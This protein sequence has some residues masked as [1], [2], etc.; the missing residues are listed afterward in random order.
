MSFWTHVIATSLAL[1]FLIFPR[2]LRWAFGV[3]L[4][5]LW[6]DILKI[7]RFTILKN[8]TIAFPDESFE[9]RKRLARL[10]M[11]HLCYNFV[12]FCLLP[13][14]NQ[15]WLQQR[16]V[17][18]GIENYERA[19]SK[20]KGVLIL[21][22]HLG[23]GDVGL[24]A[25]ALAGL[26]LHVISKKFR[27]AFA[28]Q[29]WFGVREKMGTRFLEPHGPSLA[30]DILKACKQNEAVVFVLDQFMGRP[31]GIETTFFGQKTGTAYGLALFAMKTKAPVLPVYTYRDAEL[32][33]HVVF[34]EEVIVE[35]IEDKD[36]QIRLMTQKYNDRVESIVRKYPEQWMWVHRRW[37]RWE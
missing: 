33:T 18:H 20:G 2:Q 9:A 12:E 7:R 14:M 17:L 22:L 4:G 27:N 15:K 3:F 36:L 11:H 5:T 19:R 28:N 23:N 21:S 32:R 1:S 6:F 16:V 8:L 25:L 37:K 10:S 35:K 24:A 13:F 29:L 34:E 31:Y 26:R 30:F